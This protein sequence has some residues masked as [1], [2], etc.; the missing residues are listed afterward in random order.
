MFILISDKD[1]YIS[2]SKNGCL[3]SGA[4]PHPQWALWLCCVISIEY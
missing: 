4:P 3:F 1:I 2:N